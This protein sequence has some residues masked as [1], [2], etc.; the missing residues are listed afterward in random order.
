LHSERAGINQKRHKLKIIFP[1]EMRV[2]TIACSQLKNVIPK[3][4]ECK[5]RSG[6]N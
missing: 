2:S 5:L 6:I 4:K 3:M 1:L